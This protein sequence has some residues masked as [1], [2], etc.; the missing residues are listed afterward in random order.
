MRSK[1]IFFIG[2]FVV[3]IAGLAVVQYRYLRVGLSLARLQFSQK[4]AE[5]GTD[6]RAGLYTRNQLTYLLGT[7]LEKDSTRFNT[8][9]DHMTDASRHFMD[10]FLREKLLDNQIDAPF[11]FA[12]KTRDSSFYLGS[13][14]A[15]EGSGETYT[16][17]MEVHGYL[18]AQIGQRLILELQ[19]PHLP[20]YFRTQL[21][22]LTLPSLLFLA[23]ILVA[24]LW[25][26]RTFYWQQ[27]TI[28]TTH[29]FINNLTHE[30]RTPVFS[31]SLAAKI[32]KEK[33]GKASEPL[34]DTILSQTARMS[35]HID[36][37][38]E[39]GSMERS[40]TAISL[41]PVDFR[42]HLEELCRQFEALCR[43]EGIPFTWKLPD[44]AL[45]MKAST[46]HLEHA[47]NNLL[48]NARKYGGG[49]AVHLEAR[50][51][52]RK[53]VLAVTD[54][55]PGIPPELR[56]EVFRKYY[57]I[58]QGDRPAVRGYGLGLSYVRTVVDRHK[59][60]IRL[61]AGAAKGAVF[62]IVLPLS[63]HGT[64]PV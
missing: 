28:T 59:G 17:P 38:L 20:R 29:E 8:G 5:A 11:T 12:L 33:A 25:V 47:L 13:A 14:P 10:D 45:P 54:Q 40:A 55:G 21:N 24:V 57:R 34:A 26:L 48:D 41:Q 52:G 4:I 50:V 32:L 42:P 58:P 35:D 16:Y 43:L 51:E 62:T 36:K 19:F 9:L 44:A 27:R 63:D 56:E 60:R 7:A 31:I 30:L 46:F 15:L 53:L 1:R 18:P 49:A 3:C 2:L 37:V 64:N 6:I 61:E 39:L 22:G 23:G